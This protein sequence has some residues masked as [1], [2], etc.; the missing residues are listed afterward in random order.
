[1][2]QNYVAIHYIQDRLKK[3]NP[4]FIDCVVRCFNLID[5]S[6]EPNGCLSDSAALYICAK[7][8]GYKPVLCYGLCELRGIEFYHAWLEINGI[9]IDMAIYGNANFNP[10]LANENKLSVPYI[11]PYDD[12]NIRYKKFEIDEYWMYSFIS[13]IEGK[14]FEEYMDGLPQN[15]MWKLVCMFLDRIPTENFINKL[16]KHVKNVKFE[17]N[18]YQQESMK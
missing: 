1:M 8:F 5:Q 15:A 3:F 7:E 13:Q 4:K 9:V 14:S 12:P 17:R 2:S 18:G 6:Q 10:L 11:G 16:R